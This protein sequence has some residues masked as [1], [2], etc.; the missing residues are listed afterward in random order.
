MR[1]EVVVPQVSKWHCPTGM[2]VCAEVFVPLMNGTYM[3]NYV[4]MGQEELQRF[5]RSENIILLVYNPN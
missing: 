5:E 4:Y 3:V 2:D 1:Y